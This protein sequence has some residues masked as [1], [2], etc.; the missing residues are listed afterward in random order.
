MPDL[1]CSGPLLV[2]NAGFCHVSD[3]GTVHVLSGVG[4]RTGGSFS[5]AV[6]RLGPQGAAMPGA[7]VGQWVARM[8]GALPPPRS[9]AA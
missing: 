5:T 8:W 7:L 6:T 1:H 2:A 3:G 9:D 4:S